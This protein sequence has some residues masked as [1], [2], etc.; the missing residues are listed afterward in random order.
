[1]IAD[2]DLTLSVESGTSRSLG[3]DTAVVDVS[4]RD[5][6]MAAQLILRRAPGGAWQ[7]C[8]PNR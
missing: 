3:L 8:I 2:G 1:M 6:T 7:A 5:E 4:A